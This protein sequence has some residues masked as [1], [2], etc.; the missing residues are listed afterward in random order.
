[1]KVESLAKSVGPTPVGEA[2]PRQNSAPISNSG[3][4]VQLSTLASTLQK[5]EAAL[6]KTPGMDTA[7]IE[8]ITQAIRDGR[9]KIDA[10]RIADGLIAEVRQMFEAKVG[11]G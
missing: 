3:E 9:F 5:A 6:A 2:R 1:M 7:R 11:R 10:S 4:Q 8:E